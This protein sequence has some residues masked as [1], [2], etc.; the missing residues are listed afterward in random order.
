MNVFNKKLILGL[1]GLLCSGALFATNCPQVGGYT[2][3]SHD[4]NN[5]HCSYASYKEVL[6]QLHGQRIQNNC[7]RFILTDG[8]FRQV[9][10]CR[11]DIRIKKCVCS[12]VAIP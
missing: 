9:G 1:L 8:H 3:H 4:A 5:T 7:P 6:L 12:I 11:V 10:N 2:V